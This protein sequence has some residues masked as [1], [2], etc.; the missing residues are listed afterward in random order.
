MRIEELSAEKNPFHAG[1]SVEGKGNEFAAPGRRALINL[2]L[3]STGGNAGRLILPARRG[4]AV[5]GMATE[6]EFIEFQFLAFVLGGVGLGGVAF[7]APNP[8]ERSKELVCE[9]FHFFP[10]FGV[11]FY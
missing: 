6:F 1:G 7:V 2:K 4:S 5:A 8:R 11:G 9:F 10:D 3:V